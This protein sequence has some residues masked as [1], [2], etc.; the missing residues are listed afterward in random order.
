MLVT[1]NKSRN[2]ERG[3]VGDP[4]GSRNLTGMRENR[5]FLTLCHYVPKKQTNAYGIFFVIALK[6]PL[7]DTQFTFLEK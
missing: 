5:N 7:F 1:E 3:A 2:S 4:W 6:F